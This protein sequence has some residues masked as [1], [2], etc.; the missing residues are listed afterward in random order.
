MSAFH[1]YVCQTLFPV[2]HRHVHHKVPRASGGPDTPENLVELCPGCH[3]ALHSVAYKLLSGKAS[4]QRVTDEVAMIYKNDA[5]SKRC[6]ELAQLVRDAE[7]KTREGLAGTRALCSLY[8]TLR[9][10]V[11]AMVAARCASLSMSQ[12]AYL[13]TLILADLHRHFGLNPP[14]EERLTRAVV[15]QS[16]SKSH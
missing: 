15:K 5:A 12:D 16:K 8:T 7:I 4:A 2:M 13:R 10:E 11:K 9:A 3:D 1:C 6:F 14:D